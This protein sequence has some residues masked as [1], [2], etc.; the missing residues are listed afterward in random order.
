MTLPNTV[1]QAQQQM[2]STCHYCLIVAIRGGRSGDARL[3]TRL[4]CFYAREIF[5]ADRGIT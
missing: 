1:R 3:W 5:N 4:V 2:F